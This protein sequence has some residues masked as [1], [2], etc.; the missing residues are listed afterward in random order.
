[1]RGGRERD[2]SGAHTH[3]HTI[4][5]FL[6]R[7]PALQKNKDTHSLNHT[8]S[9][10]ALVARSLGDPA[11]VV[12]FDVGAGATTAPLPAG[13]VRIRVAAASL[14]FADL[15]QVCVCVWEGGGKGRPAGGSF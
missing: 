14:N 15:L 10:P 5:R 11:A 13:H 6:F 1:M 2:N 12:E 3:T 4:C 7:P 8:Q 9:M